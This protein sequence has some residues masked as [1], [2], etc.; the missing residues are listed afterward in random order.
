M[1]GLR[2]LRLASS[3][4]LRNRFIPHSSRYRSYTK[5]SG[6]SDQKLARQFGSEEELSQSRPWATYVIPSAAVIAIAGI[7][8][9]IKYNDERRAIPKGSNQGSFSDM[10]YINKPAIGGPFKLYDTENHLVTDHDLRGNWTL[11][12]CGYTS[13][14]D[15]GP[16]E[17]QKM[18]KA[19]DI[20]ESEYSI[21]LKPVFITI[22]PERDTPDQLQAYLKEF[23][24]RIVGLTGP[25]AAV[26]QMAQEY[27]VYF[28]KVDEEGQ[29]Y[30]VE[31]SNNMYL[32]D[33]NMEIV[34]T[35]GV[36]YDALQLSDA[37][38]QEVKKATR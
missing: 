23:D 36:E 37:I 21:K 3:S 38:V 19:I 26:R 25:I 28:K 29:D 16:A 6:H 1:A 31:S 18:A 8:L 11:M 32:F 9:F 2:F 10:K 35:F 14:P 15:V 17:V 24:S 27:R 4:P 7:G 5:G 30:L 13:S 22:D 33:P 20:L 12:Y 34:K